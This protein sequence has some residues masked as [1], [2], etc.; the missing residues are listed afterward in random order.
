M[1]TSS[2][3]LNLFLL[4]NKDS[5]LAKWVLVV[6]CDF[7][8]WS[9]ILWAICWSFLLQNKAFR[10]NGV[11]KRW[12]IWFKQCYA[13]RSELFVDHFLLQ[14]KASK[15]ENGVSEWFIDLSVDYIAFVDCF[16]LQNKSSKVETSVATSWKLLPLVATG[17]TSLCLCSTHLR[18]DLCCNT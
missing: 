3:F 11:P 4:R 13:V 10:E 1:V 9:W 18:A 8:V 17:K 7:Y 16:V 6:G 2:A 14:N 5:D 15:V 12:F